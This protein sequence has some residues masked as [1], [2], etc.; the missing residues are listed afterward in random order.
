[1]TCTDNDG[2]TYAVEGGGCGPVD[3]DDTDAAVNPGAAEDCTDAIDN[4]CNGLVDTLDDTAVNCPLTC[5]DDDMDGYAREGGECGPVDCNDADGGANPGAAEICDDGVDNDCD[6]SIDEGCDPTCPDADGDG[7]LDAACGGADCDDSDAGI[8]PGVAEVCGNAVDE[9]CNGASDAE[10][11]TCPE[12]GLLIIKETKYNFEKNSLDVKGKSNVNTL[13]TLTNDQSGAVLAD[14]IQVKGGKWK[15]RVKDL[16]HAD[17]PE[18]VEV[19]NSEGCFTDKE[20][21]M[22]NRPIQGGAYHDTDH[23]EEDDD[24]EKDD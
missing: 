6:G 19:I 8:N 12:G 4:N 21:K 7:F 16:D 2:D 17:A 11:L 10:C 14:N 1:P 23:D 18:F 9:N 5:T 15:V 22:E 3:C 24:E 20:V 13:L